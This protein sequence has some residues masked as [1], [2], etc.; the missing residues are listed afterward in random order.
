MNNSAE[1]ENFL[2]EIGEFAKS[3]TD[4]VSTNAGDWSI[5]D[6][7]IL[8]K[9]YTPFLLT[10]RLFQKYLKSNFSQSSVNL[11]KKWGMMLSSQRSRIGTQTYHL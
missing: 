10:L 7:L 3:L 5:K 4:F 2:A 1:K 9:V 8:I 11:L 6:L